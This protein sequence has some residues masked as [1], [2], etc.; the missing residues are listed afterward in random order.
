MP[1]YSRRVSW[2]NRPAN[3]CP[4]EFGVSARKQE[5]VP[6]GEGLLRV[7]ERKQTAAAPDEGHLL[8]QSARR[9][10][11]LD[12]RP[13]VRLRAYEHNA[14]ALAARSISKQGRARQLVSRFSP[15]SNHAMA[16]GVVEHA[17]RERDARVI[18]SKRAKWKFST[19]SRRRSKVRAFKSL[20][21]APF[22]REIT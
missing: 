20:R 5:A 1:S 6:G 8:E 18:K 13:S 15:R 14:R 7:V 17:R 12:R 10:K 4:G 9:R 21:R 11:K 19:W 16:T 3:G 22:S 2:S